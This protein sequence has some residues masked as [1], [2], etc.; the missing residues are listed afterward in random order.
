MKSHIQ[1]STIGSTVRRVVH[2]TV[3][4]L[5]YISRCVLILASPYLSAILKSV[6]SI[7][8]KGE[9][10]HDVHR[11]ITTIYTRDSDHIHPRVHHASVRYSVLLGAIPLVI[12]GI[13]A[14][15]S[16]ESRGTKEV[17]IEYIRAQRMDSNTFKLRWSPIYDLATMVVRPPP[18]EVIIVKQSGATVVAPARQIIQRRVSDICT[19]HKMRKEYY[20]NGRSWRCKRG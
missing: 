11:S 18:P 16:T 12:F 6:L 20:N 14:L 4:W 7:S 17:Q 2:V 9:K 19:R 3:V 8:Q 10:P 1:C 15:Q 13:R 5:E